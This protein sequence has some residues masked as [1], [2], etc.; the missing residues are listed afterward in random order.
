M[1]TLCEWI[2]KKWWSSLQLPQG[3]KQER[4]R[5]AKARWCQ[6]TLAHSSYWKKKMGQEE[7]ELNSHCPEG[8]DLVTSGELVFICENVLRAVDF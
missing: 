4:P 3:R 5:A 6:I 8:T 1:F 2:G 7:E